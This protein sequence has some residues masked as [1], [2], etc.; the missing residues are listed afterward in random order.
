MYSY[1]VRAHLYPRDERIPVY[2]MPF[3]GKAERKHWFGS[4][5]S[6]EVFVNFG[7]SRG[8]KVPSPEGA[9]ITAMLWFGFD[10]TPIKV[11]TTWRMFSGVKLRAEGKIIEV[12]RA[13]EGTGIGFYSATEDAFQQI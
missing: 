9:L 7:G 8:I 10:H 12:N 5:L 13:S 2:V 3:D 1:L 6:S 11:G 4:D